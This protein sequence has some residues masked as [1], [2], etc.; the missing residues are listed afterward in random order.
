[1]PAPPAFVRDRPE[2][3]QV[4]VGPGLVGRVPSTSGPPLCPLAL[5]RRARWMLRCGLRAPELTCLPCRIMSQMSRI[6]IALVDCWILATE[7]YSQ[8][9]HVTEAK[10]V[11]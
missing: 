9:I 4:L 8:D 2:Q 1:M 7:P 5:Q 11:K 3:D 6:G 10:F